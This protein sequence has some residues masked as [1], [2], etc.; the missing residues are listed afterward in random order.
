[1]DEAA[2]AKLCDLAGAQPAAYPKDAV[3][4]A[5]G[6][7]VTD[8]FTVKSGTVRVEKAQSE[9]TKSAVV[10]ML[11]AGQ[12][13][14]EM[15]YLDDEAPCASCIADS[16]SVQVIKVSK[17]ALTAVLARE[18]ELSSKFHHQLAINVTQRLH[19]V[20][21]ISADIAEAPR[22]MALV[23]NHALPISA[24]KLLKVR[25]RLGVADIESM[26]MMC[27]AAMVNPAR[28]KSHGTLYVFESVIGF[29]TKVFGLKQF[30][31]IPVATIS[32]VLRETFTLKK[33]DGGIELL[34]KNNKSYVFYPTSG[35]DDVFEAVTNVRRAFDG[36]TRRGSLD[37][38]AFEADP[39]VKA[40]SNKEEAE[41]LAALIAR[42][43]LERYK[44]GDVIIANGS[45]P[46]TLFNI[47]K[48]RVAVEVE[49]VNEETQ[50][51]QSVK[52]L[53]LYQVR[54]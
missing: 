15:S 38:R 17:S 48:G 11:Q 23:D 6:V 39:H 50:L 21:K 52:I 42:A 44:A 34:V 13:F 36:K 4:V 46:N 16:D 47:A 3:I 14:G 30:E 41:A 5:D 27:Q 33:E 20:S 28:R 19:S 22:G 40:A 18:P 51:M 31:A 49:R 1:M 26:A 12:T 10:N 43:T 24:K 25:H 9:A 2:W 54:S 53:T 7:A 32:E 45:K 37:H 8:I 35:V 29:A